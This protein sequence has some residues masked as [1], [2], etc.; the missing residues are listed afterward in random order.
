MS[1]T[2]FLSTIFLSEFMGEFT[3]PIKTKTING[4]IIITVKD[5]LYE[6]FANTTMKDPRRIIKGK[7]RVAH[8][9]RRFQDY[10]YECE[11]EMFSL[12]AITSYSSATTF[13]HKPSTKELHNWVKVFAPRNFRELTEEIESKIT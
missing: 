3:I 8:L 10:Y 5:N 9:L 2:I 12:F 4:S 1:E 7:S 6:M 13:D 11:T